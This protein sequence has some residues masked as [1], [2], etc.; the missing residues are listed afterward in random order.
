M[1][2]NRKQFYYLSVRALALLSLCLLCTGASAQTTVT[3]VADK[4]VSGCYF[5]MLCP[6]ADVAI[7]I[8]RDADNVPDKSAVSVFSVATD[9]AKAY[10]HLLGIQK[11][12][13][14]VKAGEPV[15]IKTK[16][17]MVLPLEAASGRSGVMWNDLIC[18]SAD[19]PQ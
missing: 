7:A 9:G 17:P 8:P 10:F 15:V 3:T 16:E 18:P 12:R 5:A 14:V 6:T 13:Y 2:E 19:T 1:F 4:G 11:G